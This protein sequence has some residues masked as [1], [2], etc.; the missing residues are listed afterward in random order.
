M[1]PPD[2]LVTEEDAGD[3]R[4]MAQQFLNHKALR[5]R[6]PPQARIEVPRRYWLCAGL[7]VAEAAELLAHGRVRR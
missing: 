3:R 1:H 2:M 4:S 7:S 5:D 6:F